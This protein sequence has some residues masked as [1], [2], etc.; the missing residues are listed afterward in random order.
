MTTTA[1]L[2]LVLL[3]GAAPTT[4]AQG[5]PA[6]LRVGT[7][8]LEQLGFRKNPPRPPDAPARIAAFVR[9]LGVAVLA[10]QEVGGAD[11]LAPVAEALGPRWDFVLGTTGGFT[12]DPG[13]INVGFLFDQDRVE[14]LAAHELAGLPRERQQLAL[15]HRVPVV[16]AF[17]AR[18][19]G[20]DFRLVS[21]HLKAGRRPDDERKRLLEVAALRDALR[22]LLAGPDEDQDLLVLGDFNHT[23][24]TAE[25]Q[26]FC[27]GGLLRY[28]QSTTERPTILHFPEPIDHVAATQGILEE[29]V[30][31]SRTV[32]DGAAVADRAA[33]RAC[34]SDHLPVT[35]E[36]ACDADRDPRAHL[37]APARAAPLP[38]ARRAAF[39]APA[40]AAVAAATPRPPAGIEPGARIELVLRQGGRHEGILLVPLG[41]WIHLDLGKGTRAAFPRENVEG[42]FE[43][44]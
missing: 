14:L 17:R 35:V 31:A 15:F 27:E 39:A 24:G 37:R 22:Q 3:L 43:R 30:A 6:P 8:N 21:V 2:L 12:Q 13:Q 36:L 4:L 18:A 16:A 28:L 38:A 42:L 19:G 1:R 5:A 20:F 44:R 10:V 26:A 40:A 7:W 34:Y 33:W 25:A 23:Y 29:L 32:H 9:E 11:A 41:D